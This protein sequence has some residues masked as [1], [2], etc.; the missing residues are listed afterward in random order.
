M[1]DDKVLDRY[2]RLERHLRYI[3]IEPCGPRKKPDRPVAATPQY[4]HLRSNNNKIQE[5]MSRVRPTA[6]AFVDA[7]SGGQLAKTGQMWPNP[8]SLHLAAELPH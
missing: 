2:E 3:T 7:T 4:I 1:T 5:T 8:L 6:R